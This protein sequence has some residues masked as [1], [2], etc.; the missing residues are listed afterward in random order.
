MATKLVVKNC[1]ECP[2]GVSDEDPELPQM[3]CSEI[4]R[5]KIEW[6]DKD[7]FDDIYPTGYIPSICP[8]IKQSIII[9]IDEKVNMYPW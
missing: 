3:V 1:I 6:K 9:E 2:F 5:Q 4:H 8:L 7:G